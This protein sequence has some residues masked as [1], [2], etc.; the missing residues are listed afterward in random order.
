MSASKDDLINFV[1][2]KQKNN[3]VACKYLKVSN[4]YSLMV[5]F[6]CL[7]FRGRVPEST[8]VVLAVP[9]RSQTARTHNFVCVCVCVCV[10]VLERVC[11]LLQ[12][13]YV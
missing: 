2:K 12:R 1:K 11:V 5:Y 13:Y 9:S 6:D 3:G 10:D 4:K 8:C 7:S